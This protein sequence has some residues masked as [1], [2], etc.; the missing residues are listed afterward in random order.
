MKNINFYLVI[1]IFALT[2]FFHNKKTGIDAELSHISLQLSNLGRDD[3]SNDE[4]VVRIETTELLYSISE[5]KKMYHFE[6]ICF[7][8]IFLILT[9][10]IC[11]NQLRQKKNYILFKEFKDRVDTKENANN[12]VVREMVGTIKTILDIASLC[13]NNPQLF[14]T[15]FKKQL[16]F[17]PSYEESIVKNI[18]K[19]ANLYYDGIVDYM[20]TK[21]PNLTKEELD[22]S[23]MIALDIPS[24]SMQTLYNQTNTT[25]YYNR[26]TRLR[27]T[28]GIGSDRNLDTYITSLVLEMQ[29]TKNNNYYLPK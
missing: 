12:Y 24:H 7:T 2:A 6:K 28:L 5:I 9:T 1:A 15:K 21:H 16:L 11:I 19:L 23:S 3:Y 18:S 20:K 17:D 22:F 8:S 14:Y 10:V 26:R 4:D 29:Q 27:R 13:N 25:S